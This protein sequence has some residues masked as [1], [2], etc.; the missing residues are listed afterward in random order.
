MAQLAEELVGRRTVTSV[1]LGPRV[2]AVPA[3]AEPPVRWYVPEP[4]D[5]AGRVLDHRALRV[6]GGVLG[7]EQH[8]SAEVE[9]LLRGSARMRRDQVQPP[10]VRLALRQPGDGDAVHHR[11]RVAGV[12]GVMPPEQAGVELDRTLE[13]VD[14]SLDPARTSGQQRRELGR[15]GRDR[16]C[17][18]LQGGELPSRYAVVGRIRTVA[19]KWRPYSVFVKGFVRAALNAVRPVDVGAKSEHLALARR[20]RGREPRAG[21]PRRDLG[22]VK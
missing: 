13:V 1:Q 15:V 10:R 16:H 4:D 8:R 18:L 11:H 20:L 12:V 9:S 21:R 14:G 3:R 2:G 5:G 17:R 6:V 7:V 19:G 22:S